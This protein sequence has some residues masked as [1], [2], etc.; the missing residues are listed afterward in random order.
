MP[1]TVTENI[2]VVNPDGSNITVQPDGTQVQFNTD[3]TQVTVNADGTTET[4]VRP[5]MEQT[6]DAVDTSALIEFGTQI[7]IYFSSIRSDVEGTLDGFF[8]PVI[9]LDEGLNATYERELAKYSKKLDAAE[10]D[11]YAMLDEGIAALEAGTISEAQAI[12]AAERILSEFS[13]DL[14]A[15]EKDLA[16]Q[17]SAY[18]KQIQKKQQLVER[19]L[20]KAST[21]TQNM[22]ATTGYNF[23][24]YS[25]TS[26]SDWKIPLYHVS[27]AA[28]AV[29]KDYPI[30]IM[31]EPGVN[32]EAIVAA[33]NWIPKLTDLGY[34]VWIGGYAGDVG[35]S[36]GSGSPWMKAEA[37]KFSNIGLMDIPAQIEH[38]RT[39]SGA[40]K[41]TFVGH[42]QGN[43]SMF[44]GLA[45]RESSYFANVLNRVIAA[46]PCVFKPAIY[47]DWEAIAQ[48]YYG[49]VE[50]MGIFYEESDA[51]LNAKSAQKVCQQFGTFST[52]CRE[53]QD[54]AGARRSLFNQFYQEQISHAGVF[55]EPIDYF[56]WVYGNDSNRL[57]T[58][59]DMSLVTQ[60]PV[61]FWY[62]ENDAECPVAD[63]EAIQ[64]SIG[65]SVFANTLLNTDH[66][67]W[68]YIEGDAFLSKFVAA[69][70][71]GDPANYAD[72]AT[73]VFGPGVNAVWNGFWD[74][75]YNFNEAV[76]LAS[77]L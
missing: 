42:S 11:I 52:V 30:F 6:F 28:V 37:G 63:N 38:I 12:Q 46:A 2:K 62:N 1:D 29:T 49:L 32:A 8:G 9:A 56:T 57:S 65:T 75:T 19:S 34:D 44:Y 50:R 64:N 16:K 60:V 4:V 43:A 7:E 22:A 3:G 40:D 45:K 58:E 74:G 54:F 53:F 47:S 61:T 5:P 35:S 76:G 18:D 51:K 10:E 77:Q 39:I 33:S 24:H 21:E 59:V 14:T 25:V 48:K 26:I 41:V 69:V 70:E 31:S 13:K 72:H 15:L 68:A 55:Q 27:N 36:G 23:E 17:V 67:F 73:D 20:Q 66:D 71:T